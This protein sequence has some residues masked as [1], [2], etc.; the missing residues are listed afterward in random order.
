M[1][2]GLCTSTGSMPLV[3]RTILP[4]EA[5]FHS[6]MVSQ[7]RRGEL[8]FA[9]LECAFD[10]RD[11]CLWCEGLAAEGAEDV[12]RVRVDEEDAH[13]TA[14]LAVESVQPVVVEVRLARRSVGCAVGAACR[15]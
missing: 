2:T 5:W 11:E 3:V 7:W 6:G 8:L 15:G 1:R 4:C 13:L 12:A 10:R 14:R 9:P